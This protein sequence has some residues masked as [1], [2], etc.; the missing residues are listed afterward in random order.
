[1]SLFT[2]QTILYDESGATNPSVSRL[3]SVVPQVKYDAFF[4]VLLSDMNQASEYIEIKLNGVN[5]GICE[6]N[7]EGTEGK[8]FFHDCMA[9]NKNGK[10]IVRHELI[11]ENGTIHVGITSY[12]VDA[13]ST[14]CVW[15]YVKTYTV[16]RITLIPSGKLI[17]QR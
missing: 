4:D 17:F 15:E 5:F 2:V 14:Q 7:K 6:P 3:I 13:P 12:G 8:C 9:Y 11:S 10:S 16:V 1:M